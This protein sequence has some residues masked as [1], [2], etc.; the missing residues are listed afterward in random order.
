MI[1]NKFKPNKI[2]FS[3]YSKRIYGKIC[4]IGKT[5]S[6]KIKTLNYIEL[7]FTYNV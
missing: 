3:R 5:M 6:Y 4:S 2:I 1:G 7:N